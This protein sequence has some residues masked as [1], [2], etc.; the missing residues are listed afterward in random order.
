MKALTHDAT[1]GGLRSIEAVK[2][3]KGGTKI[4]TRVGPKNPAISKGEIT[5]SFRA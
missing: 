1:E 5:S 3:V 2:P 4:P